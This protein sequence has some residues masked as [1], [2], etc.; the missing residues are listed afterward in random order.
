MTHYSDTFIETVDEE[1]D[2]Y[3][4]GGPEL[5]ILCCY[6]LEREQ[7]EELRERWNINVIVY[8]ARLMRRLVDIQ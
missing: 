3:R 6:N 4:F 5:L 1:M 2:A 8:P 7:E